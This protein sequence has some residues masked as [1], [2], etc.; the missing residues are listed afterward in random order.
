MRAWVVACAVLSA[1][2]ALAVEVGLSAAGVYGG[3]VAQ[4]VAAARVT[5]EAGA[6]WARINF[7]LDV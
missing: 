4:P 6:T 7:R 5:H 1:S 2:P 3:D